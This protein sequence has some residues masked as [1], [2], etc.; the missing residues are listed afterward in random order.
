MS[1]SASLDWTSS[2]TS[3]VENGGDPTF[4]TLQITKSS[5]SISSSSDANAALLVSGDVA[6]AGLLWAQS[7][8]TDVRYRVSDEDVK[9]ILSQIQSVLPSLLQIQVYRYQMRKPS[10][11]PNIMFGPKAQDLQKIFPEIVEDSTDVL[12][13]DYDSLACATLVGVQEIAHEL[14]TQK[15]KNKL[16]NQRILEQNDRLRDQSDRIRE[17]SDRIRELNEKLKLLTERI[18]TIEKYLGSI[19]G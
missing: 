10:T 14:N 1:G 6:I 4:N 7:L 13:V 5:S 12:G 11:I 15:E 17:Q 8:R 3:N 18:G 9:I 2:N 16:Q 19:T